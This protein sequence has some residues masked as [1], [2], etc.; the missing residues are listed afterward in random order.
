MPR[1]AVAEV[2]TAPGRGGIAVVRLHGGAAGKILGELF[3]PAGADQIQPGTLRVG[4][5]VH[6]GAPI[7]E[8]VLARTPLGWEINLHGG[9]AGVRELLDALAAAGVHV[10]SAD[11]QMPSDLA[12]PAHPRWN[13]PAIGAELLA[14]LGGAASPTVAACLC[15]QWSGGLSRLARQ[16]LDSEADPLPPALADAL[17]T[18][19]AT[20]PSVSKLLAGAEVAIA[21]PPNAGKSTLANALWG[22][23]ASIVHDLAGTTRDWVRQ[24]ALLCDV[25]VW[26]T[27]TA[28]LWEAMDTIDAQAVTRARRCIEAA[29]LVILARGPEA[30]TPP[31]WLARMNPLTVAC[32]TDIARPAE[33]Y[34]VAVCAPT[35]EGLD[36]LAA[37]IVGRLGLRELIDRDALAFTARQSELLRQAGEAARQGRGPRARALLGELLAG[38]AEGA[39]IS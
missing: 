5:L 27:D 2:L 21:G 17:L 39:E 34:D 8:A 15:E 30:F 14:R 13:N 26:L 33:P 32:K 11:P 24:R 12:G 37:A 29:D 18:A 20:W 23:D 3:R 1:P 10:R 35:G 36:D 19:A 25:P 28:G 38:S 6:E 16:G 22:T 7:D 4:R 31:D 9:P